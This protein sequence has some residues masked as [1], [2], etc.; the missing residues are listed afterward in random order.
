MPERTPANKQRIF[1][2]GHS[3]HNEQTRPARKQIQSRALPIRLPTGPRGL[4]MRPVRVE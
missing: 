3:N 1:T 4:V 2:I